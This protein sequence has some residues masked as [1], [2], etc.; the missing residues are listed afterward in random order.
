MLWWKWIQKAKSWIIM[1]KSVIKNCI[2]RWAF[3]AQLFLSPCLQTFTFNY[4]T[5][6]RKFL[7][8]ILVS[9]MVLYQ[10]VTLFNYWNFFL[11][12]KTNLAKKLQLKLQRK[13]CVRC[14]AIYMIYPHSRTEFIF[15]RAYIRNMVRPSTIVP[16]G[17][18]WRAAQTT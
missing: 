18:L 1:I 8:L 11:S 12:K 15:S 16:C 13:H 6:L 10:S 5:K 2:C 17:L 7:N 4:K 3:L 14:V 9:K